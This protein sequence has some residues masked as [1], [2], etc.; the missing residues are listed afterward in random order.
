MLCGG[1]V[2][3]RVD[4]QLSPRALKT[5]LLHPSAPWQVAAGAAGSEEPITVAHIVVEAAALA[6]DISHSPDIVGK[7]VWP[8]M[9][10]HARLSQH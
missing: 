10:V 5:G 9:A 4:P 8:P 3:P 7:S 2:S 1:D 6:G